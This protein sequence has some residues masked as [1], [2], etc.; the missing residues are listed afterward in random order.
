[1]T[2]PLWHNA[3]R[4]TTTWDTQLF[5]QCPQ[6]MSAKWSIQ[7]GI[8]KCPNQLKN[9]LVNFLATMSKLGIASRSNQL[10]NHLVG[11]FSNPTNHNP[12]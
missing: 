6:Y 2:T 7:L 8:A 11:R 9:Q 12:S 1:M 10:M 4:V 5:R 3:S